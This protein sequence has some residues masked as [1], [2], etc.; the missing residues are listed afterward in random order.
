MDVNHEGI[1]FSRPWR[2][3]GEGPSTVAT[4]EGARN[5]NEGSK[6]YTPQD[7]RFTQ[8]KGHL[9]AYLMAW[10]DSGRTVTITSLGTNGPS[11]AAKI[12]RVELLGRRERLDFTRD[13][14]GL[15]INLPPQAPS[16]YVHGLKVSGNGLTL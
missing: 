1:F 14:T 4:G 12:E 16:D 7:F 6:A 3:Y 9:Y 5:F 8:L 2:V 10:P 11:A 13:S 15:V